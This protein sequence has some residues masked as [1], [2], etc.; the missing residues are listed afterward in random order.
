MS[1]QALPGKPGHQDFID[2]HLGPFAQSVAACLRT[3]L[4][5]FNRARDG[6][7]QESLSKAIDGG[8]VDVQQLCGLQRLSF[9]KRPIPER[10]QYSSNR[11]G[12]VLTFLDFDH[13]L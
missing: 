11:I 8:P 3:S 2:D 10:S 1:E 5:R 6:I 9:C 13:W 4:T 7:G 12:P